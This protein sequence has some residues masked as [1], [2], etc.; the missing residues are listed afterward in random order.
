MAPQIA[1]SRGVA[2]KGTYGRTRGR[3]SAARK[4]AIVRE[5]RQPGA[6]LSA[7]ARRHAM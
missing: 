1:E 2:S 5:L 6:T 4:A 3:W 7:V